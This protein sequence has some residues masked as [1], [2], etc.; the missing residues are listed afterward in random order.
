VKKGMRYFHF[1]KKKKK[2]GGLVD[3]LLQGVV[4]EAFFLIL[5]LKIRIDNPNFQ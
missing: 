4:N 2:I 5:L 1:Q 3:L